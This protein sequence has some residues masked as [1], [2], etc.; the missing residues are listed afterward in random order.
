MFNRFRGCHPDYRAFGPACETYKLV[1]INLPDHDSQIGFRE[2][3]VDAD[4]SASAG[5]AEIDHPCVQRIVSNYSASRSNRSRDEVSEIGIVHGWMEAPSYQYRHLRELKF[6]S[7]T[8]QPLQDYWQDRLHRGGPSFVR[9]R[10]GHPSR[11]QAS[12]QIHKRRA[13]QGMIECLF[14]CL[15]H[16]FHDGNTGRTKHGHIRVFRN[17]DFTEAP[18]IF[19]CY[20]HPVQLA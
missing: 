3:R 19:Q 20:K 8:V 13:P 2:L 15:H 7:C 11:S 1:R 18:T 5:P 10:Y 12:D 14:Q 4:R 17:I 9:N 6:Q 16:V